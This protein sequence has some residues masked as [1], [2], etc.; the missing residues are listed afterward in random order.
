MGEFDVVSEGS[1][2]ELSLIVDW[3]P[4]IGMEFESEDE[5]WKFWLNYGAKM[6]FCVRKHFKNCDKHGEITSRG[7]VCS[8]E[9]YYSKKANYV[10]KRAGRAKCVR[11]ETRTGCK[12]RMG[13]KLVKGSGKYMVYDFV[14]EHNHA[15]SGSVPDEGV[16]LQHEAAQVSVIILACICVYPTWIV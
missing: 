6:G 3:I 14:G 16:P 13:V 4:R 11:P 8:N 1:E 5:A 15:L 10:D 12:V 9:G 7:F 2:K